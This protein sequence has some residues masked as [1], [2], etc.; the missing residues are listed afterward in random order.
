MRQLFDVV[1]ILQ[2]HRVV[3]VVFGFDVGQHRRRQV[4]LAG[5]RLPGASRIIKKDTV[6]STSMVGIAANIRF[7]INFSIIR[8]VSP[9]V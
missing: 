8:S 7:M 1:E 2:V 4:F 9:T 6:I 3:E 5:E